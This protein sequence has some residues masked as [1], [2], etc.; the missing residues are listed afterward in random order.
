ME[1]KPMLGDQDNCRNQGGKQD[2]Q[3]RCPDAAAPGREVA[4]VFT[5]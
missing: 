4:R 1:R 3:Q 2:D 5:I